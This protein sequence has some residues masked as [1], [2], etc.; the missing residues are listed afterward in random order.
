MDQSQRLTLVTPLSSG[1][2]SRQ[3]NLIAGLQ[4]RRF[5]GQLAVAF[6]AQDGLSAAPA[7][8]V[9]V[10]ANGVQLVAVLACVPKSQNHLTRC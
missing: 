1:G 8:A 7:V 3:V 6:V 9:D 4:V 2:R 10:F 5:A